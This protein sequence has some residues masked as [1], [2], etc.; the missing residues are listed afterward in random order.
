MINDIWTV[1]WRDWLV[2]K[3]RLGRYVFARMISPLLYLVAFGWGIGRNIS[4]G[5]S[6]YLDFIVPGIVALNSMT[7]S[8]NAV[9]S[10]LNMS[11]LYHKTLE[12]Y[13]IAPIGA[14][15]F[16][17]GKIL[18]GV[19]RGMISSAVIICLSFLFGAQFLV[20]GYFLLILVL[21]CALF[22]AL[23]F[24]AA[25]Y[26]NSH[27]DMSNFSTYVLLPMSFLCATFF[28][29]SHFP[30]VVRWFIELLPLTH[31]SQALRS[32]AGG[33]AVSFLSVAV[34]IVYFLLFFGVGIWQIKKMSD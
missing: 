17:T 5:Q 13:L 2:L 3:R 9:G 10:P 23:G 29:T 14:V 24:V 8:F 34:M 21:N 27:E 15:S 4:V 26:L 11:R 18:A 30:K 32:V 1:F 12:E 16:V 25:M 19:L 22:A 20:N 6:N 7:I 28:S 31:A 33:G